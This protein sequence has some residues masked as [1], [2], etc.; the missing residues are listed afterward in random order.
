MTHDQ[1]S[2]NAKSGSPQSQIRTLI[3][4]DE[5][6]I[7]RGLRDRLAEIDGI[8][9]V[10]ECAN[11]TEAVERIL[12]EQI[13][14]VLLDV[15]MPDIDG[16]EVVRQVGPERMPLVIFVTAYDEYA[17][18]AFELNALD[19]L[20]KPF[21]EERLRQSIARA[22]EKLKEQDQRALIERLQTLLTPRTASLQKRL[23]VKNDE[24]YEFVDIDSIDWAE[25]ANNYVQLHC[26][27]KN[28]LMSE[29]LNNLEKRLNPHGFVRVHRRHLVNA[30]R[31]VA[32]HP[33]LSGTFV[34]QLRNG[35]RIGTGRQYK[36]TVRD[37]LNT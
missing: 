9:I 1:H 20:L 25:S 32:V 24:A 35:V 33:M 16:L 2:S 3:V 13:D 34:L 29:T 14:L 22:A 27:T 37:L 26:G 21:D 36:D 8:E 17:V 31:I 6:L 19:Y 10:G 15:Q 7:R 5:P 23:T 28:Y 4:D 12:S 30:R 11:G 18:R